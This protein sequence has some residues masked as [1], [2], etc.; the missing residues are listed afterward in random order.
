MFESSNFQFPKDHIESWEDHKLFQEKYL[1]GSAARFSQLGTIDHGT[2]LFETRA[3][4]G[5][6]VCL[7]FP[8]SLTI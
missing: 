2:K 7:A 1:I 3:Y 5:Q 6:L 4:R 8:S